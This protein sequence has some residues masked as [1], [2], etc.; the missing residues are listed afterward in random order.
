LQD[1][2]L[3]G[4]SRGAH[5]RNPGSLPRDVTEAALRRAADRIERVGPGCVDGR[6][7]RELLLAEIRRHVD[8]D[9][10][11]WVLTD[12]ETEVGSDPLAA[13]PCLAELPRLIRLKYSTDVN[14][15]TRLRSPVASLHAATA[16]RLERA[17]VWREMLS[18][19]QV[20]DIASAVLRD[21]FGCW[22][23]LDLWRTAPAPPF[24]AADL[25]YLAA[26]VPRV[27]A[28]LRRLQA[29]T[30]D[31]ARPAGDR[32]GPV[33]LVLS[34]DL[35]VRAQTADT[36]A[37]LRALVPAE[38]DRQPVPAG[39]YNVGAQLIAAELGVDAHPPRTRV[40]LPEGPWLTLSAAR[41]TGAEAAGDIAVG[42]EAAS[43]RDRLDLFSRAHGLTRRESEVMLALPRGLD[44]RQLASDL[45][46]S[47]NTVQ[48]HLKSIFDKTGT[49]S[50]AALLARALGG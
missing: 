12:P 23:F 36:D 43:A 25:D 1:P 29:A 20:T 48:D 46:V 16:G 47:E 13:V 41:M 32:R 8:F 42:I 44:T 28:R 15:W 21:R 24:A 34:P 19:Y 26:V 33:V 22:A 4:F 45:F 17:L 40:H 7:L 10:Y 39:A 14:R 9:A 35:E 3:P 30:F 27:T 38:A 5:P 49:R 2:I 11:A 6:V 37:Y 50:R 18:G 31:G